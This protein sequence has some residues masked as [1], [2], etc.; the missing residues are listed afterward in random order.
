[1][2]FP[3]RASFTEGGE[4]RGIGDVVSYGCFI[5]YRAILPRKAYIETTSLKVLKLNRLSVRA[6]ML[7]QRS[8]TSG[9]DFRYLMQA[10]FILFMRADREDEDSF[11]QWWPETLLYVGRFQSAFEIFARS[12]SKSYF[13]RVKCLLA[14]KDVADLKEQLEL[15]KTDRR[16]IPSWQFDS[17]SPSVLLGLE[18]LGKKYNLRL[19]SDASAA[20]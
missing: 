10:D 9:I 11:S 16:R 2:I 15:Y 13:D 14:A 7:E 5:L 1:M 18:N 12:V 4:W 17:F 8:K 20:C 19:D 6:D 3:C